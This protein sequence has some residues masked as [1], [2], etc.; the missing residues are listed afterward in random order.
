MTT[1]FRQ[2]QSPRLP[3]NHP[4]HVERIL[5]KQERRDIWWRKA[6]MGFAHVLWW[7]MWLGLATGLI[8][9][10]WNALS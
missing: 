3:P 5:S 4:Q 7:A 8:A 6:L 1:A 10:T 9:A 2:N